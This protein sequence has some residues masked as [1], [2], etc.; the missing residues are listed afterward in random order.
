MNFR[1]KVTGNDINKEL[2]EF[3]ARAIKLPVD[4]QLAWEKILTNLWSKSDFTGRSLLP[5]L[6]G[7]LGLFE[8]TAM[9]GESVQEVLGDDIEGFCSALV[10][11]EGA[12][13]YRD[14]WRNQLNNTVAKKI[15]NGRSL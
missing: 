10:G 4:F 15:G 3:Q 2:N 7:V 5:I 1:D 13:N 12:K 8:E 9:E 14:K 11:E 6:D